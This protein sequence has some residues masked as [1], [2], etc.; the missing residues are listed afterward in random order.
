MT[1]SPT[2][3]RV[4][5][6]T[7]FL[8]Y[9][10]VMK[11]YT[12]LKGLARSFALAISVLA[13]LAPNAA[14]ADY[15]TADE[16]A[17]IDCAD[18]NTIDPTKVRYSQDTISRNFSTNGTVQNLIDELNDSIKTAADIPPITL[19]EINPDQVVRGDGNMIAAGVY[20][21]DNR[22]LY[23]FTT[24]TKPIRCTKKTDALTRGDRRKFTTDNNGTSIQFAD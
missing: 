15:Y 23:A 9:E 11:V 8:T 6:L 13:I 24:T 10:D 2:H 5:W 14:W 18:N 22:R 3:A 19:V 21:L 16:F 17:G 7:P 1:I 20:S 4:E 12:S